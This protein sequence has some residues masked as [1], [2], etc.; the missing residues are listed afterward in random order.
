MDMSLQMPF[1]IPGIGLIALGSLLLWRT[2]RYDL[3]GMAWDSLRQV[4]LGRW[5]E[6]APTA[7]ET[8]WREISGEKSTAGKAKRAASTV[9]GHFLTQAVSLGA[10]HIIVAGLLVAAIGWFVY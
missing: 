2:S 10:I 4:L 7:V 9:A 5:T 6:E 3:K 8:K 1:L